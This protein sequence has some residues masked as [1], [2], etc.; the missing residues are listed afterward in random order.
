MKAMV[1]PMQNP[2]M[3][4]PS[5]GKPASPVAEGGVEVVEDAPGRQRTDV[6][7]ERREVVVGQHR[8]AGAVVD[9]RR[10]RQPADVGQPLAHVLDVPGDPERL[11]DHDHP[12]HGRALR[13]VDRQRGLVSH[14]RTVAAPARS[15]RP[16]R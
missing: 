5:A 6:G 15:A 11:L 16:W 1:P 3:P 8:V 2:T 10:H 12:A 14:A 7:P 9:V 4:A 13:M